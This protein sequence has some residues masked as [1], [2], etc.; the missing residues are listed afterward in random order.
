MTRVRP[1]CRL[2]EVGQPGTRPELVGK[3]VRYFATPQTSMLIELAPSI[4][5]FKG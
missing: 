3:T 4:I 1:D 5:S 2:L